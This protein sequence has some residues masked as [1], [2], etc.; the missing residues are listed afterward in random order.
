MPILMF[1]LFLLFPAASAQGA[2]AGLNLCCS[3]VIPSLFPFMVLARML[4][5][6]GVLVQDN[7][8]TRGIARFFHLSPAG[9]SVLLIGSVCGY[10]M[11]AKTAAG[12]CRRNVLSPSEAAYLMTFGNNGGP[13]F[14]VATV[15]I[16]YFQSALFGV[17]LLC[18]HLG[19]SLVAGSFLRLF[20]QTPTLV[21]V[22]P[23]KEKISFSAL[24]TGAIGDGFSSVL[25]V[26]GIVVFFSALFS[27]LKQA[28]AVALPFARW[29]FGEVLLC[30]LLE[31][32]SGLKQLAVLFSGDDLSLCFASFLFSFGGMS[33]LCQTVSFL[34]PCGIKTAPCLWGKALC[35]V[36]SVLLSRLWAVSG[37][38]ALCFVLLC[39]LI[40]SAVEKPDGTIQISGK[41]NPK[42]IGNQHP[43]G[44]RI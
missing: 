6:S 16:A 2:K 4:T 9:V 29:P 17:K 43:A 1:L 42:H 14:A 40:T 35:A 39:V 19:A 18:C 5:D 28:A 20:F 21:P 11:G 3:S 22:S 37:F 12:L 36:L 31:M 13:A 26:S 10:P 24:L 44:R 7:F 38:A 25:Q 32:T 23:K 15:G 27:V 30:G 33:I 34:T 8:L 41:R